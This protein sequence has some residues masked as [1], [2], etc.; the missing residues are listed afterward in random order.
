MQLGLNTAHCHLLMHFATAATCAGMGTNVALLWDKAAKMLQECSTM[1]PGS[2]D[3][4]AVLDNVEQVM[5]K[6]Q[7]LPTPRPKQSGRSWC[8]N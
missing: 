4:D 7:E 8:S 3:A 6:L 2:A 1:Q 5:V